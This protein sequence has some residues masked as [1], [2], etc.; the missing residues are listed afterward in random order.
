MNKDIF[1]E[2]KTNIILILSAIIVGLITS[3]VTQIFSFTAKKIFDLLKNNEDFEILNV[4]ILGYEG[5]TLPIFSC[6]F[7]AICICMLIKFFKIERWHG[8]A[9]TIYAAHQHG[10]TLNIQRG[11]QSTL[12]AF[13][14]ISGGASVGIYGPL[15][16]FGGTLGAFLRRRKFMPNIPH[17]IVLGAGVAAAISAGF[18]SPIAGIV[19]AHEVVLRHFSVKAIASISLASISSSILAKEIDFVSPPLQFVNIPFELY[20]AVPGL[21]LTGIFSAL[22]AFIFMKSLMYHSKISS[23]L[24]LPFCYRPFIP[25]LICGFIGMFLPEVIGLGSETISN[26]ITTIH[27]IQFLLLL[28][29]L[30]IFLSSLC[31]GFGLFGGVLSPAMLIGVCCGAIIYNLSFFG[32]NESLNAILAISGMAAV[33]SSVIGAPITAIILVFELTGSY[34]YAIASIFPIALS[35]LIT[36]LM[37]GLSFFDAQLKSR[38]INIDFGREHFLMEQIKISEFVNKDYLSLDINIS[39]SKAIAQFKL[40]NAT[41]AYFKDEN[42]VFLGKLKI[43]NI[44]NLKNTRAINF[45]ETKYLSLKPSNNITESIKKLSNFVG[46]SVPVI[47]KDKKIIG[48]ISENDI[49]KAYEKIKNEIRIIEKN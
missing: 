4:S 37:F 41:E 26:I 44:I 46:E 30:K 49:L 3:L 47:D 28:L 24:N 36:Y 32:D 6:I 39:T 35:N 12:A 33:S 11:F 7:A 43:T 23:S 19:F 45:I 21:I 22:V 31:I 14:S 8:P 25:A 16:H 1:K 18:S 29:I 40:H 9:D 42:D 5:N 27:P 10:G 15:V 48:I 13:F 38:N 2:L 20:N 34:N 17:D